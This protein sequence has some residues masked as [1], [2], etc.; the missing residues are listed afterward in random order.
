MAM[1]TSPVFSRSIFLLVCFPTA[2]NLDV[3]LAIRDMHEVGVFLLIVIINK[4]Q[5][6]SGRT[7]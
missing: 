2:K 3:N 1:I 6:V 4:N 5:R 7:C